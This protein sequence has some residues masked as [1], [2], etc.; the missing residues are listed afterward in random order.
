MYGHRASFLPSCAAPWG[1]P[2]RLT[3]QAGPGNAF[4]SPPSDKTS[5]RAAVIVEAAQASMNVLVEIVRELGPSEAG[6]ARS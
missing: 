2:P 3:W 6:V 1:G 4:L 5:R